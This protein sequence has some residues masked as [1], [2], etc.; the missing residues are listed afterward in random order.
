MFPRAERMQTF[1]PH[2]FSTLPVRI[3]AL[4][5]AGV[6]VIRLDEGSPDLP[7]APFIVDALSEA[8]A[9]PEAHCYQPHRGTLPLRQA[10]SA[11]YQR[12]YGVDLD[13][14]SQ[15]IPL[16]GSKEGIFHLLQAMINPGDLVLAPDPGY[17]TYIRGT[18]FAGG[19]I[20]PFT[21]LPERG[22]LP[23]LGS[24]PPEIARQAK[25]I[26]LNYP[27]NPTGGTASLE[28]FAQAVE[29]ARNNNLLLCHDAAYAQVTFDGYRAPSP[30]QIHGSED[31]VIEFNTLSKSHNMAG[32]RV[33]AAVGRSDVL[34]TLYT[35]K[36]NAD[37]GHFYPILHAATVAMTGSQEW[38]VERNEVYRLRRDIV[39]EA[40][41]AAGLAA[42]C[43]AGSLYVWSPIPSGWKAEDFVSAL[44]EQTGVSL[45]PGTLFGKNGE[46]YLRLSITAPFERI[47]TAMERLSK[48]IRTAAHP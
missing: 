33:G 41:Q 43:P 7:P 23:D 45:T 8:A 39:F 10:W 14:A 21:L 35:L 47:Q 28:F 3:A 17:I 48:F 26:F 6:D 40:L 29:F 20:Y 9:R 4:S 15:V 38:L 19:T 25:I 13:P 2:F 30:L 27:N 34:Q 46:G 36:T 32:W 31:V 42:Q 12:L 24:I 18:Q 44:L 22:W 37:S 1:T 11:M 5:A 16:L